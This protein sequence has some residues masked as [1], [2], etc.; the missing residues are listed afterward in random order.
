M[1]TRDSVWQ[2][3]VGY[4]QN[5]FIDQNILTIGYTAWNGYLNQGR[6]M[7]V[8]HVLDGVSPSIDWHIDTVTFNQAFMPQAHVKNCFQVLQLENDAVTALLRAIITY[9]P[10]QAI[11]VLVIGNGATDMNLLQQLKISPADCY[12]QVQ[13]HWADF[14]PDLITQR[15]HR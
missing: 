9:D 12:K 5:R 8:C 3:D 15:R 7:V 2:G 10:T 11:V 14:Q 1:Q 13:Q 4:W 6:G